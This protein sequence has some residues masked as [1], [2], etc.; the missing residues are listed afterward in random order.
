[1]HRKC[2]HAA[3]YGAYTGVT[4]S[5]GD[6]E[7]RAYVPYV[8]LKGGL[9]CRLAEVGKHRGTITQ[10][11]RLCAYSVKRGTNSRQPTSEAVS[12]LELAV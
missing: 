1:M 10:A 12:E 6:L 5:T 4:G 11:L 3:R 2:F 7:S 9:T 8:T